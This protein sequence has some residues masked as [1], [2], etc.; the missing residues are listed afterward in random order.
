MKNPSGRRQVIPF[1]RD[2][3]FVPTEFLYHDPTMLRNYGE[4]IL[5]F[6]M[7]DPNVR[8]AFATARENVNGYVLVSEPVSIDMIEGVFDL[9]KGTW[10]NF[11]N[12]KCRLDKA[13]EYGVNDAEKLCKYFPK[14]INKDLALLKNWIPIYNMTLQPSGNITCK[15]FV[16]LLQ[17]HLEL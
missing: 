7:H 4:R 12:P 14:F 8:E 10:E 9:E 3:Q 2:I 15:I 17:E 16:I 6:N 11:Y 5:I 1:G 13:E